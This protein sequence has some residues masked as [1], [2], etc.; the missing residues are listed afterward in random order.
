MLNDRDYM[1]SPGPGR[2]TPGGGFDTASAKSCILTLIAINVAMFLLIPANSHYF[3]TLCLSSAGLREGHYF[4][5]VTAMF[6]HGGFFHLL[7]NMWGLYLFGSLV[8]PLLGVPRF[9]TVY[10]V[11]GI[12]GNLLFLA[13]NWNGPAILLGA[14]GAL[15]GV[16]MAV[17]MLL[18]NVR[19]LL[20]F[21]PIPIKASTLVVVFAVIEILSEMSGT[22]FQIAHLAHLGGFLG[23]YVTI[24]IMLG[25]RVNWDLSQLFGKKRGPQLY[26]A[27]PPPPRDVP[28][29]SASEADDGTPVSR[30]EVDFLLDKISRSGINSLSAREH[31]RLRRARE[32]LRKR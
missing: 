3:N 11:S 8:A 18:P 27:P 6:M 2:K 17:A 26:Q 29:N 13:F 31:A 32:E 4:E 30:D 5:V 24:K 15:Y 23:G 22:R 1:R 16:M 12:L 9:L 14:S 10:F 20:L 25:N 7:F 19:F 21:P 28:G